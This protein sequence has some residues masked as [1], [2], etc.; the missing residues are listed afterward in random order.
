[1]ETVNGVKPS[2]VLVMI[3][4]RVSKISANHGKFSHLWASVLHVQMVRSHQMMAIT[5]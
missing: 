4:D 5:A 2:L 3:R 1:M